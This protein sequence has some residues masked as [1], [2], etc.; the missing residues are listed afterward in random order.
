M[1]ILHTHIN[2][3]LHLFL[4]HIYIIQPSIIPV[5]PMHTYLTHTHSHYLHTSTLAMHIYPTH[6]HL[7]YSCTPI[8]LMH[9]CPTHVH[10]S[11]SYTPILPTHT[12]TTHT[13]LSYSYI[14]ALLIHSPIFRLK[15]NA[16]RVSA[17]QRKSVQVPVQSCTFTDFPLTRCGLR[18]VGSRPVPHYPAA[19]FL[20]TSLHH[21]PI[22]R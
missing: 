19:P 21:C 15:L 1:S 22:V 10:L 8:L 14:L 20:I 7:S 12:C 4:Y 16:S 13:H 17:S 6:V 2:F 11:H 18:C 3:N 5:L 9:T